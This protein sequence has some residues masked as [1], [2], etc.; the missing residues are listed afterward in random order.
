MTL[1]ELGEKLAITYDEVTIL[2][3]L[4]INSFDLVNKFEDEIEAKQDYLRSQ[5]EEEE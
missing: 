3:L 1:K 4:N 2:E 5:L